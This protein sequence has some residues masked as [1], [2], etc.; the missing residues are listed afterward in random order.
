VS[1]DTISRT[2]TAAFWAVLTTGLF[3]ITRRRYSIPRQF[4]SYFEGAAT[5]S[6]GGGG[7]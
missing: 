7:L 3:T 6:R 2:V 1:W 5:G 4:L